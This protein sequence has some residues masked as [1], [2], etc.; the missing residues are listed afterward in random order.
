MPL[1][2][3]TKEKIDELKK[4]EEEKNTEYNILEQV[5]I[6]NIWLN[7]LEKIEKEYNSWLKQKDNV[8]KQE[9]KSKTKNKK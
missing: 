7:E 8:S 2:N 6:E 5:T 3:L 4:Q 9:L 1:Y